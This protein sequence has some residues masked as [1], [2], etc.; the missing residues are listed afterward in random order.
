MLTD[1]I[2]KVMQPLDEHPREAKHEWE[3]SLPPTARIPAL[4]VGVQ[5]DG[6][7]PLG[8]V[9]QPLQGTRLNKGAGLWRHHSRYI[10]ILVH[11]V[12]R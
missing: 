3:R 2:R 5:G 10:C 7:P 4:T 11:L 1:T 9:L 6:V 8:V 12:H